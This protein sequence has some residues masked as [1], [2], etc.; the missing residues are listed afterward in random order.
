MIFFACVEPGSRGV[1][2]PL[3]DMSLPPQDE[4]PVI[5]SQAAKAKLAKKTDAKDAHAT[6]EEEGKVGSRKGLGA[7]HSGRE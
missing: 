6:E 2:I 3:L 5:D 1:Q 4:T 7:R